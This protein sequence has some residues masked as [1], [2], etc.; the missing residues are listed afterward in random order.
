MDT[1]YGYVHALKLLPVIALKLYA[2]FT[3]AVDS[4]RFTGAILVDR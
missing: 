3:Q 1:P 4:V 2:N